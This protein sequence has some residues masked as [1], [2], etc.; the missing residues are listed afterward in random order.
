LSNYKFFNCLK[1]EKK[2]WLCLIPEIPEQHGII[3]K[4][5]DHNIP[6]LSINCRTEEGST[7][8]IK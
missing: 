7:E 1:K 3:I 2:N 4:E 8:E 6:N 5:T